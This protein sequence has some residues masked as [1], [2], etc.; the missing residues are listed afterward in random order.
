MPDFSATCVA[1]APDNDGP[2]DTNG[3]AGLSGQAGAWVFAVAGDT[4]TS[5]TFR[6]QRVAPNPRLLI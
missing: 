2:I 1:P 5:G 4:L 3:A 6:G